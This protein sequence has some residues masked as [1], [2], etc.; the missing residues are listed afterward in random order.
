MCSNTCLFPLLCVVVVAMAIEI[1]PQ[2]QFAPVTILDPPTATSL[3]RTPLIV[4]VRLRSS[5]FVCVPRVRVRLSSQPASDV[6]TGLCLAAL[7]CASNRPPPGI[8]AHELNISVCFNNAVFVARFSNE[9]KLHGS[10]WR[11]GWLY[12]R[13]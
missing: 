13:W 2:P 11:S 1:D 12:R 8:M 5:A 6:T 10:H 3:Q 9:T 4:C 7:R